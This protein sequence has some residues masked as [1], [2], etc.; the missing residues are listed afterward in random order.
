MAK[1]GSYHEE[2][3][4]EEAPPPLVKKKKRGPTKLAKVI[5]LTIEHNQKSHL[6]LNAKNKP[7]GPTAKPFS[8]YLG[9]AARNRLDILINK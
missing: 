5:A 1:S 6:E 3:H 4:Y 2:E 8:S 9:S 7:K